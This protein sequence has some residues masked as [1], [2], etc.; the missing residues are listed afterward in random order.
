MPDQQVPM[1]IT[2]RVPDSLPPERV[3]SVIK[4]VGSVIK[5]RIILLQ[6]YPDLFL[7]T[8]SSVGSPELTLI[9]CAPDFQ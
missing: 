5:T 3:G 6:C 4:R 8:L 7:T 2:R 1:I 9:I